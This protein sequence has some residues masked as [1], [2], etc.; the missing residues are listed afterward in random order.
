[1]PHD[2]KDSEADAGIVTMVRMPASAETFSR[3][4]TESKA[5]SMDPEWVEVGPAS[6][7]GYAAPAQKQY[8]AVC[9]DVLSVGGRK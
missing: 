1:M 4:L 2:I 5:M 9:S 6:G 8:A 7:C 3:L